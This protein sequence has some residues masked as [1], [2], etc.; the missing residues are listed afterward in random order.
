MFWRN[1]NGRL[2]SLRNGLI[3]VN[4]LTV[5]ETNPP[6]E[7]GPY[8]VVPTS[9]GEI[10]HIRANAYAVPDALLAF[11]IFAV[12]FAAEIGLCA[13]LRRT[14]FPPLVRNGLAFVPLLF[15]A[16]HLVQIG[17]SFFRARTHYVIDRTARTF[18]ANSK[19]LAPLNEIAVVRWVRVSDKWGRGKTWAVALE[20]GGASRYEHGRQ[21]LL[22]PP[23]WAAPYDDEAKALAKSLGLIFGHN[24]GSRHFVPPVKAAH[25]NFGTGRRFS[26]HWD[27]I[28][29]TF[30]ATFSF[31][32]MNASV[33]STTVSVPFPR[34]CAIHFAHACSPFL[35]IRRKVKKAKWDCGI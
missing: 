19:P 20:K 27:A 3:N 24:G 35:C 18:T 10:L 26:Y 17:I 1:W 2:L 4:K 16:F 15:A 7:Y 21:Y 13:F 22:M 31:S 29:T 9:E 32:G 23:L 34:G 28:L 25:L 30:A 5:M 6:F 14:V 12:L 33:W 8:Q 11:L